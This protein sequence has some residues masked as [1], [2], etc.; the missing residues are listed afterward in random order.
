MKGEREFPLFTSIS[1]KHILA[2]MTSEFESAPAHPLVE[3]V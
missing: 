2:R 3:P 1:S